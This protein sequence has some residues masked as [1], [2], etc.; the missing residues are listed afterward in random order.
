MI[1]TKNK[2]QTNIYLFIVHYF[3]SLFFLVTQKLNLVCNRCATSLT[4]PWPG[5]PLMCS[6]IGGRGTRL[7][8]GARWMS[9]RLRSE[10][11]DWADVMLRS[12]LNSAS[13]CE[14]VASRFVS[15]ASRSSAGGQANVQRGGAAEKES[16]K[17]G[18]WCM[19][20]GTWCG[21]HMWRVTYDGR[22]GSGSL[23]NGPVAPS[24][25]SS[26]CLFCGF[27]VSLTFFM[28]TWK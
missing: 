7:Y 15:S 3:F 26:F 2:K 28:L 27:G 10:A 14:L 21:K 1:T 4:L 13:R 25:R 22:A 19:L 16:R 12:A 23:Q 11:R 9:C 17:I 20:I 8:L 24:L 6:P 18:A 5:P